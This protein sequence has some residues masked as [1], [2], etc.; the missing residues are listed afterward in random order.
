MSLITKRLVGIAASTLV[1][2]FI[3]V[4]AHAQIDVLTGGDFLWYYSEDGDRV[5]TSTYTFNRSMILNSVGFID[6]DNDNMFNS[7]SINGNVQTFSSSNLLSAVDGVRWLSLSSPITLQQGDT[8]SVSTRWN[9]WQAYP[10]DEIPEMSE[11]RLRRYFST[12][13]SS[14]VTYGGTNRLPNGGIDTNLSNSN[15]RVSASNP[16]SNVAP[17]PG[18]FALALTGGAA[19]LGICIRRRRNA[20]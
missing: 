13:A 10:E 19:L 11:W 5:V 4:A 20:G 3:S 1:L 15:L 9:L 12:D 18:S 6:P 17:E 14:N 2:S 7:F 16:G 8:V